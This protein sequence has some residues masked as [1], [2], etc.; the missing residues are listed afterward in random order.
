MKPRN[1]YYKGT[2]EHLKS[3]AAEYIDSGFD[4]EIVEGELTV[5]AGKR[6]VQTKKKG[7]GNEQSDR[8][9]KRERNFGY[10]RTTERSN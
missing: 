8:W 5:F 9:S 7:K 4:T 6:P 1:L 10:A 3:L 2:D